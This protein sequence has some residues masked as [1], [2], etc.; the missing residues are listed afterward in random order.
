MLASNLV[1]HVDLE[2][3][4]APIF[5]YEIVVLLVCIYIYNYI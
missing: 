1:A 4:K 3:K 2:Q 5:F